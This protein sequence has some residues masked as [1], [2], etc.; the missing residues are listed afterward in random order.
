MGLA[1]R[2]ACPLGMPA[3]RC[4]LAVIAG[5]M[6]TT[7]WRISPTGEG[8]CQAAARG[9]P[10]SGPGLCCATE[11]RRQGPEGRHQWQ[12]SFVCMEVKISLTPASRGFALS[13]PFGRWPHSP[14]PCVCRTTVHL[15]APGVNVI[16]TS[17]GSD[18]RY[19]MVAGT[20]LATPLVSGTAALLMAADP[21]ADYRTIRWGAHASE[22]LRCA[23]PPRLPTLL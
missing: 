12:P 3:Y 14:S 13:H 9:R 7:G 6:R 11:R 16:T 4:M 1:S 17:V 21:L 5:L 20:S 10:T 18:S 2:P 15:A 23:G 8:A 22:R 19:E